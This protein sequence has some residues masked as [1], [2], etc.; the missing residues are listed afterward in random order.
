MRRGASFK[1]CSLEISDAFIGAAVSF[2]GTTATAVGA[3]H[4]EFGLV[5]AGESTAD[6]PLLVLLVDVREVD[7]WG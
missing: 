3:S 5:F 2:D 6:K 7:A 4:S 1:S